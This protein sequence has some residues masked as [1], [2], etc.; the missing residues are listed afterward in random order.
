MMGRKA[1][2][3]HGDSVYICGFEFGE[4]IPDH[5]TFSKTR[6]RKR[7]ESSLFQQIFLKIVRCCMKQKLID[8]KEMASDGSYI[9]VFSAIYG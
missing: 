5:S 2:N 3:E 4:K 6:V 7:N 1:V 8:G 9:P